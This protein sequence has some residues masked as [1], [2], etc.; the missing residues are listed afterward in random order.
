MG[1]GKV[2]SRPE[3]RHRCSP[4]WTYS[5]PG[6][7]CGPPFGAPPDGRR[8]A[9][10]PSGY[11]YPAGTVWECECGQ[12]WVSTGP[13]YRNAPGF[14]DFRRERRGERRRRERRSA[15]SE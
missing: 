14:V 13:P 5:E 8:W 2:V 11:D 12:T 15:A 4:G 3:E 1:N 10:P 9:Y 6:E 7:D